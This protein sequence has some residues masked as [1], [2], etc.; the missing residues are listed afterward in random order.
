MNAVPPSFDAALASDPHEVRWAALHDAAAVVATLGGI[1]AAPPAGAFASLAR[2]ADP[3]RRERAEHGVADLV[4]VLEPGIEA[5]LAVNARGADP[6]PAAQALWREFD[7]G[8]E[9]V[10]AMLGAPP[11]A[12]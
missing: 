3:L 8:R 12:A 7:A 5:L 11:R 1:E 9:A 4:A 10:L 2:H 6:R